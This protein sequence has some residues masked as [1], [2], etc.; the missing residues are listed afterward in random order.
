MF[1]RTIIFLVFFL[2]FLERPGGRGSVWWVLWTLRATLSHRT[3]T[4]GGAK[5]MTGT[6]VFPL[7][8]MGS[9]E[10]ELFLGIKILILHG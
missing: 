5:L 6:L 1:L 10:F 7:F 4:G 2:I 9:F 3:Q 8:I